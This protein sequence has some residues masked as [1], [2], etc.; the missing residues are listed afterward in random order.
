MTTMDTSVY[1]KKLAMFNPNIVRTSIRHSGI[2][3]MNEF[4]SSTSDSI[5][6]FKSNEDNM[7]IKRQT[8]QLDHGPIRSP[9][10][11]GHDH[12]QFYNSLGGGFIVRHDLNKQQ[13][14]QQFAFMERKSGPQN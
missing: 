5:Q 8:H 12:Q 6:S 1:S 14:Q 3:D 11:F 4:G 9:P 7:S 10:D 2:H 13:Q